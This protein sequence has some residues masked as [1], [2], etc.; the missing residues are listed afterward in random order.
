MLLAGQALE[1]LRQ[2]RRIL[3]ALSVIDRA[4]SKPLREPIGGSTA[5]WSNHSRTR[6]GPSWTSC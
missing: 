6:I 3:P 2:K 1:S 4:C 5:P